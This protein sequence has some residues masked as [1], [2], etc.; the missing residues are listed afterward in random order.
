MELLKIL[1]TNVFTCFKAYEAIKICSDKLLKKLKLQ[2]QNMLIMTSCDGREACLIKNL[3]QTQI[4]KLCHLEVP[5]GTIKLCN[6]YVTCKCSFCG[7]PQVAFN[8]SSLSAPACQRSWSK[9]I[10]FPPFCLFSSFE[11]FFSHEQR[12][13]RA[14]AVASRF[15]FVRQEVG[16]TTLSSPKQRCISLYKVL[17]RDVEKC[18][19]YLLT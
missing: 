3:K 4:P 7:A 10:F 15:F 5:S 2:S 9:K 12:F 19:I 8:F 16:T 11:H 13:L 18:W 6:C 14:S 1:Q 17:I